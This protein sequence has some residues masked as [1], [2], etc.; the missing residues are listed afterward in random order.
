VMCGP[1]RTALRGT[2]EGYGPYVS[3]TRKESP[4]GSTGRFDMARRRR[5]SAP[6]W[7]NLI[8]LGIESQ[9]VIC[10]RVAKLAAG[11][12][13]AALEAQLMVSEKILQGVSAG[14]KLMLGATP[15]SVVQGYRKKVR[16]NAKR[17]A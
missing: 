2:L 4:S 14:T 8:M 10:L 15:N 13:Q 7:T 6:T 12:P 11:G 9:Q 1:K 5:P 17:L 3:R 16:A